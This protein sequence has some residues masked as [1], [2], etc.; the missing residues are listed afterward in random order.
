MRTLRRAIS[1]M[2]RIPRI[3]PPSQIRDQQFAIRNFEY[4]PEKLDVGHWILDVRASA[5]DG[6]VAQRLE[7]GTHNSRK[8]FCVRFHCFAHRRRHY[9]IPPTSIRIALRRVALFCRKNAQ[10][11]ENDR[12]RF[13][14]A[15]HSLA[16]F[17]TTVL[18]AGLTQ[19]RA[20]NRALP[21]SEGSRD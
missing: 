1:I 15:S 18:N 13:R 3:T 11:V 6:P 19:V 5:S 10:T 4:V 17:R 8:R 14:V 7:Q 12:E 20:V 16:D 9:V 21:Q 2:Q